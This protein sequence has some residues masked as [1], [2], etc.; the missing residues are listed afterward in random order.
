MK[1][2][3]IEILRIIRGL[4]TNMPILM[5]YG[6]YKESIEQYSKWREDKDLGAAKRQEY[7]RRNPDAIADYDLQRARVLLYT[8]GMMDK[9]LKENS[10]KIGLAFE[11]ATNL[12][13]GYAAVG[14]AALGFLATKLSFVKKAIDKMVQKQPKSKNI[15]SM[16]IAVVGGVAGVLMAYPAYNFLSGVESK[17]HRK[18]KFETMEKELQDPRIFVV[19]DEE[20]K[21]VFKENL[22]EKSKDLIKNTTKRSLKKEIDSLKTISKE[23]LKYEKEQTKFKE[24]YAED[25]T[26]YEIP[27]SE[28]DIKDA[29]KDKVLLSVLIK[30]IN[31][32]S[33]SYR[34]KMQRITD[35]MITMSFALGSLFTLAYERI[36]KK[37]NLKSYSLPAGMGVLLLV[38]STFFANWAQRRASHIGRFKAIQELKQNPE[39]LVYISKRK[40]SGIEDSEI[41]LE[42]K[43]KTS[44]FNLIKNF[45]KYNKEYKEWKQTDDYT[46]EDISKAMEKVEISEEQLRDGKRLQKNLFK[47]LYKVDKNTQRY[48]SDIDVLSES[49]KYPITLILGT[50]GSVLG[51]KYLANLRN[52]VKPADV[53]KN[54]AKYLGIISI[55][56]IPS[57]FINSYFAKAQKMGARIS[58]MMTMQEMEDNRFFADYSQYETQ[59]SN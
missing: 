10:N 54:S 29:K 7:L 55:F 11:T 41:Q 42:G 5:D 22:P 2:K 43:Q 12:G 20:Q 37:M 53:F 30:E 14:G 52:A 45:F 56:T 31:T 21:K 9:S 33:Q 51:M 47:T 58:D 25:K 48:S 13:L 3:I 28:K 1:C 15:I 40:T 23:T 17:I 39:K 50:I 26:L 8:V 34:E 19:L 4:K 18:R 16:A 32:K 27:L 59:I 44:T 24:K 49:V 35:N 57:L 6:A 36:A 46:G 38:S